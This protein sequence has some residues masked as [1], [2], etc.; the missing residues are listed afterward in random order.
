MDCVPHFQH[1]YKASLNLN[2]HHA[3][4]MTGKLT[5][6]LTT[7]YL[8]PLLSKAMTSHAN[9]NPDHDL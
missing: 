8:S 5:I 2:G 4:Y 7:Q 1:V 9:A 3:L 6:N